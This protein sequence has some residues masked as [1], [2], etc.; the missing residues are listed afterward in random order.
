[1]N[2]LVDKQFLL[3]TGATFGLG[4]IFASPNPH[5]KGSDKNGCR[6]GTADRGEGCGP[7]KLL[8]RCPKQPRDLHKPP[9][10]I[11]RGIAQTTCFSSPVHSPS[12]Y[13][14]PTHKHTRARTHTNHHTKTPPDH[15]RSQFFIRTLKVGKKFRRKFGE[16]FRNNSAERNI[17]KKF[18]LEIFVENFA[19]IIRKISRLELFKHSIY[20]PGY[21]PL[22]L[23]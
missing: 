17:G 12:T 19:K 6:L 22:P 5:H 10:I 9:S 4:K 11:P 2:R 13:M 18:N 1:M 3:I 15:N 23:E 16:F 21:A 8:L 14:T 7:E 20:R